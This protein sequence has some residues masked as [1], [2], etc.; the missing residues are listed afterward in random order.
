MSNKQPLTESEALAKA[1]KNAG[2]SVFAIGVFNLVANTL[3]YAFTDSSDIS[4]LILVIGGN[5]ILSIVMII[6][7]SKIKR[8]I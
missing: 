6:L 3:L 1:V 7:G 4:Y 8:I 2:N 5:A